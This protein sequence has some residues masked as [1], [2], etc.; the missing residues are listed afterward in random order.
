MT[1]VQT[2]PIS[3]RLKMGINTASAIGSLRGGRC[4]LDHARQLNHKPN[5]R[6]RS[7]PPIQLTTNDAWPKYLQSAY[8]L[9]TSRYYDP[10]YDG[11]FPNN[12]LGLP[13]IAWQNPQTYQGRLYLGL[14]QLSKLL[15]GRGALIRR[16]VLL[17][18]RITDALLGSFYRHVLTLVSINVIR[19]WAFDHCHK[20]LEDHAREVI[21]LL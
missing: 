14:F 5:A 4:S 3:M 12:P 18:I 8:T 10:K 1:I 21:A 6:V 13:M 15:Y 19:Q 11:R 2:I 7:A 16:I 17:P 20:M 9:N